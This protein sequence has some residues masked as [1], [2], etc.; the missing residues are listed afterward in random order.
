M[1]AVSVPLVSD[2]FKAN[3]CACSFVRT[4]PLG[5]AGIGPTRPCKPPLL[6]NMPSSFGSVTLSRFER[7]LPGGRHDFLFKVVFG[8]DATAARFFGVSK[9]TIWRWRHDRSPLPRHVAEALFSLVQDRVAEAHLAQ[10]ELRTFLREPPKPPR[11]LTGCCAKRHRK[12]TKWPM[13][14]EDWAALAD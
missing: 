7:R 3:S 1:S 8:S 2:R 11:G 12:L 4:R 13:T 14:P 5:S 10:T 9:M 6:T